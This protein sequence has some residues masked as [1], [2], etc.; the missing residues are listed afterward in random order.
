MIPCNLNQ[1]NIAIWW[2]LSHKLGVKWWYPPNGWF[3]MENLINMD[4][5]GVPQ[6]WMMGNLTGNPH[7]KW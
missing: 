5:L 3:T 4:D 7:I 2:F 1:F 6:N